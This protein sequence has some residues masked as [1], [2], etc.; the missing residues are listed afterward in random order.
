MF[1]CALVFFDKMWVCRDSTHSRHLK[2]IG[3]GGVEGVYK[4]LRYLNFTRHAMRFHA[5]CNVHGITPDVVSK[6]FMSHNTC[7]KGTCVH[8]EAELPVVETLLVFDFFHLVHECLNFERGQN[9]IDRMRC[10]RY[11]QAADEHI[12][13]ADG[14]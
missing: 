12:T 9:A 1:L 10:R 3:D 8:T 6:L 11:R 14:L 4:R 13:I 2:F 5:V 7:N